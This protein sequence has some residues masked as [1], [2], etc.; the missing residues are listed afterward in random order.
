MPRYLVC[1]RKV[2]STGKYMSDTKEGLCTLCRAEVIYNTRLLRQCEDGQLVCINCVPNDI[3]IKLP[4]ITPQ[5]LAELSKVVGHDISIEE[6]Q[7]MIDEFNNKDD[8]LD[9][10]LKAQAEIKQNTKTFMG[11]IKERLASLFKS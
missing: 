9:W 6:M 1:T 7:L 10:F 11:S 2:N 4:K 8:R 5:D 3:E